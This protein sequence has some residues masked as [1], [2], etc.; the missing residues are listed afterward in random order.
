MEL[1]RLLGHRVDRRP[2]RGRQADARRPPAQT[3]LTP[4]PRKVTAHGTPLA[5]ARR[6]FGAAGLAGASLDRLRACL[7]ADV[8]HASRGSGS[9]WTGR[10]YELGQTMTLKLKEEVTAAAAGAGE[11][12]AAGTVWRQ[13]RQE[14]PQAGVDA[15]RRTRPGTGSG[16]DPDAAVRRPGVPPGR[17]VHGGGRRRS[18]RQPAP[19]TARRD[20]RPVGRVGRAGGRGRRSGIAAPAAST[21]TWRP[22]T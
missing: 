5:T 15:P 11:A 9:C 1:R 6:C 17:G 19:T 7:D 22:A 8:R 20:E 12:T 14:R 16:D 4:S 21:P 2:A 18:L 10:S 3:P 13:G